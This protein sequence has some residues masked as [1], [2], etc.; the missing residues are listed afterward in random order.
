MSTDSG[1]ETCSEDHRPLASGRRRKSAINYGKI[2]ED[3]SFSEFNGF[4]IYS[5]ED[6][7]L[8]LRYAA[9]NSRLPFDR[10]SA[11][12]LNYFADIVLHKSSKNLYLYL[13]N[14]CLQIWHMGPQVQ[15][16]LEAFKDQIKSPMNSMFLHT[17]I[18]YHN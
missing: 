8:S 14:R 15:L 11:E 5:F 12:E 10:L 9:A 2:V 6:D 3:M 17:Y 18:K 16:T 7:D 1:S 4:E 13:R